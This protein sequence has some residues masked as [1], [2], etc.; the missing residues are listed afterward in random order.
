MATLQN[1]QIDQSF[2][3]LLKTDD[4]GNITATAKAITDGAG[5]ATNMEM[6]NTET[7]F[8]SGTVDFTGA[9]VIGAGG[10]AGLESGAGSDSMQS[11]AS[12]TTNPA[13]A[14][15]DESIAL[16]E[17]ASAGGAAGIAIGKDATQGSFDGV[18]VGP[19][20]SSASN[21][22]AIGPFATTTG[23]QGMAIGHTSNA[24]NSGTAVGRRTDATGN[25][26]FAGG[27][28][29]QATGN[30]SIAIGNAA[31]A[32]AGESMAYGDNAV[33]SSTSAAAF[34][35]YAEATNNYAIAFGRTSVASGD[36]AVA[37]GQQT[38]A[39][40]AGAV[41]MGRQVT[42]D[43]AD[44]THVRALKI[45]APDGAALGGNGIT[46]LS[47]DGTSSEVTVTNNSELAINGTP[48]GGGGGGIVS[49][50]LPQF[51]VPNTAQ[52]DICYAVV[53]IPANTFGNG[54][55]LEFRSFE[56][57]DTL[58]NTCYESYWFSE[59]SQTVGQAV[60]GDASAKQQAG[61]QSSTNGVTYYQK[62]LFITAAGT[63][64]YTY[65]TPNETGNE[66]V[67]SGDPVEVQTIDWSVAQYFYF[68]A[69]NDSTTGS[70]TNYGTILRKI[71]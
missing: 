27:N 1:A 41:A 39:A 66:T 51:T 54:D 67:R 24:T 11:A 45:V 31:N 46:M 5:N 49:F 6:S 25:N 23:N 52:S 48:I 40:Q 44:T 3:A 7:K 53:T 33:A 42:A 56:N 34:G 69:Y 68:Q 9:T 32:S 18:V 36:G 16:G 43:T 15:G 50:E 26:S 20:A 21:G 28:E 17:N 19:G 13:A 70:V 2:G 60:V 35:Q 64:V 29:A 8:S 62:T 47:P 71:N 12:L 37:F 4:N 30:A 38:S 14:T 58:N 57:R 59:Q 55:I 63:A 22:T 61:L 10:A 65:G